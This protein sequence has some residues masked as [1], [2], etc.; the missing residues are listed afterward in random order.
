MHT[1][2][3]TP[4]LIFECDTE[5]ARGK[6]NVNYFKGERKKKCEGAINIADNIFST[7]EPHLPF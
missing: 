4:R 2:S 1:S 6:R 7:D 3:S 5:S